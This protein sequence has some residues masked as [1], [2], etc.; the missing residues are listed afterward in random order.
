MSDEP[1]I[2]VGVDW[3]ATF[4]QPGPGGSVSVVYCYAFQRGGAVWGD[5][6]S[7]CGIAERDHVITPIEVS[8]Q[9]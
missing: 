9:A 7:R 1:I 2:E 8:E 6:C 3:A 5:I 4:A